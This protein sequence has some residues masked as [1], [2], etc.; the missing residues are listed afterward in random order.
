VG[1]TSGF[2]WSSTIEL[3]FSRNFGL[4]SRHDDVF[5]A[6]RNALYFSFTKEF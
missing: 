2:V 5:S 4:E 1:L 3:F 6:G